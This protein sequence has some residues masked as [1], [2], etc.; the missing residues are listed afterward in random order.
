ML[1][2]QYSDDPSETVT[3]EHEWEGQ[4]ERG[5]NLVRHYRPRHVLSQS[6]KFDIAGDLH[7]L[8]VA[9][10]ISESPP[11]LLS[12]IGVPSPV[13]DAPTS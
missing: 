8:P 12:T 1:V 4:R 3:G 2:S 7:D 11:T 10:R 5:L 6:L 13:S 9:K